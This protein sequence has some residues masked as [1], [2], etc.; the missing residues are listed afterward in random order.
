MSHTTGIV[1]ETI[2]DL[3]GLIPIVHARC[4]MKAVITRGLGRLLEIRLCFTMIEVEI[5][6]KA[7]SR[8]IIEVVLGVKSHLRVI[9]L[10]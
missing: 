7:L 4:I 2:I 9:I 3:Y 6:C 10:S 8:T 5:W 1:V